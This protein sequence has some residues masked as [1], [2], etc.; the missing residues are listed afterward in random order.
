MS[1]LGWL[2]SSLSSVFRPHYLSSVEDHGCYVGGP[3]DFGSH[4]ARDFRYA[5]YWAL[6]ESTVY[7]SSIHRWSA[8]Y[9]RRKGHYKYIRPIYS[10]AYRL[11]EM[12]AA[13]IQGGQLDAQAGDGT[14]RPSALPIETE[15]DLIRPPIA[16]FWRDSNWAVEKAVY[17]RMGCICG[18][19]PVV[20]HDDRK[21][22]RICAEVLHPKCLRDLGTDE[23]GNVR[24]YV[25]QELRRNPEYNPA[26]TVRQ[27]EIAPARDLNVREYVVYTEA[28]WREGETIIY[29][30]FRGDGPQMEPYNWRGEDEDGDELPSRW[31]AD[32]GFVPMV[33]NPHIK[34][35]PGS[36]W[37]H[38]EFASALCKIDEASDLGSL[39]H[40]QIRKVVRGAWFVAGARKPLDDP[41]VSEPDATDNDRQPGRQRNPMMYV[42]AVGATITPMVLPLD[43][44]FSS[45]EIM[46]QVQELERDFPELRFDRMRSQV[47][48]DAS[49]KALREARKPAETK[50]HER[51]AGYDDAM[52]RLHKMSLSM[53]AMN[54]Y[55][56]YDTLPERDGYESGLF[57]HQIGVR[58]VFGVDPL[59]MAELDVQRANAVAIWVGAGMPL[60]LA[61]DRSGWTEEQLAQFDAEKT[62]ADTQAVQQAQLMAPPAPEPAIPAGP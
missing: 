10:P 16:R 1:L 33:I 48:G 54:R 53:G 22:R 15:N 55:P 7:D 14:R 43:L 13:H 35:R 32:Y 11:A 42:P 39:Q 58:T 3:D 36:P 38:S 62:R 21:N 29:E 45:I 20:L 30:T 12:H 25:R 31:T 52:A 51:R 47:S 6:Y 56:I 41:E 61:L 28:C 57:D 44:Q 4:Q 23:R 34:V 24:W 8:E 19:A 18:D 9:K 49:A 50:F 2:S 40:D 27:G 26:R 59:D 46:N 37:G 5:L 17:A 60:R